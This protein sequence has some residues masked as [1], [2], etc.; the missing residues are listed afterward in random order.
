MKYAVS[1]EQFIEFMES[2]GY[3]VKWTDSRKNITYTNKDGHA[4]RDYRLH[5][6]KYLKENMEY[7]FGIR[8]EIITGAAQGGHEVKSDESIGYAD[9][10]L[11]DG[12]KLAGTDAGNSDD[13]RYCHGD[14]RNGKSSDYAGADGREVITAADGASGRTG[15]GV[16]TDEGTD[17]RYKH[18]HFGEP[19]YGKPS[20]GEFDNKYFEAD[21]RIDE[22]NITTGWEPEREILFSYLGS[23]AESDEVHEAESLDIADTDSSNSDFRIDT[24]LSAERMMMLF[25]DNFNSLTPEEKR[26]RIEEKRSA[27]KTRAFCEI[28]DLVIKRLN[29]GSDSDYEEDNDDDIDEG[30]YPHLSM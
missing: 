15:G 13:G 20:D 11:S 14:K 18:L 1:K 24:L 29:E 23:G 25:G 2:E 8:K 22:G 16:E 27:D 5:E 26:R 3:S 9:R 4:C 6:K 12:Q 10:N 30:G 7:E 28:C 17:G 21:G 19:G